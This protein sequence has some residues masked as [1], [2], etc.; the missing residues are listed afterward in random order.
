[1]LY[2]DNSMVKTVYGLPWQPH[3]DKS[4]NGI[5]NTYLPRVYFVF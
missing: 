3:L 2:A 1:M 4:E 5:H